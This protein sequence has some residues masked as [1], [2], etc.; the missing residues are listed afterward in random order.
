MQNL[1]QLTSVNEL[2]TE[3][4]LELRVDLRVEEQVEPTQDADYVVEAVVNWP[5]LLVDG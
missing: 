3:L 5:Q 4:H 2:A 1:T